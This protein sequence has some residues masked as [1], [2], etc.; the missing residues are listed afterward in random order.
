MAAPAP[1]IELEVGERLVRVSNP[2]RCCS[3][4]AVRRSSISS[5]SEGIGE[6]PSPPNV[7]EMPGEPHRAQPSRARDHVKEA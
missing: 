7:P 1:A 5:E 3:R 2:G 4:P 6:A